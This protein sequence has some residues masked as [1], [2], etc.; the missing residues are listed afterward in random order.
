MAEADKR[1]A[2]DDTVADWVWKG[3]PA[4]TTVDERTRRRVWV[5][6]LPIVFCLYILAFIDRSNIS[7]AKLGMNKPA[8]EQ[9]LG[10]DDAII[11]LGTGMFFWTY[12]ILE[13]PS[14]LSVHKRGARW[15][16]AHILILW[17]I[18]AALMGFLG[19]PLL[20]T[21]F[22]WLPHIPESESVPW[23][24]A[25]ARHWNG[26]GENPESQF[27]CLRLAL[28]FFEGGFFPTV[29]MY[30]S[31]WF[32]AEHRA[33]AMATFMAAIPLSLTI[34]TPLSQ[35]I[36]DHVHWGGL[37]GWRWIYILEGVAPA[38]AAFVVLFCLPDRP[39]SCTWLKQDERDWLLKTL[40]EEHRDRAAREHGAW[41]H[42]VGLVLLLTTVYFCQNVPSYALATFMPSIAKAQLG[43]SDSTASWI[44]SLFF[45][46]SFIS[47]QINGWHS[48]LRRERF[49]HVAIPYIVL[50]CGLALFSFLKSAPILGFVILMVTGGCCIYSILPAF[51]PIPTMFLGS[52]AAASA[53]GF[54]NMIGNLGGSLGPT[55]V[56]RAAKEG[57]FPKAMA[58]AVVFPFI[59]AAIVLLVGYFRKNR[60]PS[61]GTSTS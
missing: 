25:L 5:H 42:H 45:L 1:R 30:L 21:L 4:A 39:Q 7:V 56:G 33:K 51:W 54:I 52:A 3:R 46:I 44:T 23:L 36:S 35:M 11:G 58:L 14:T 43:V 60:S 50:G 6:L 18:C 9:G 27:Y 40:D 55:V 13:I 61:P 53:I 26:L 10:F 37:A 47:I 24:G 49:W 8:A 16:F 17:G 57:N 29:V 22:G 20:A 48:D 15:V 59:G 32:K 34:G 38:L 41:R 19:M 28:G 31:I 2:W 12:W